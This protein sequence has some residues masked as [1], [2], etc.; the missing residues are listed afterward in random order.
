[1][2]AK[3]LWIINEQKETFV[4]EK[5]MKGL[6]N[7]LG[8]YKDDDGILKLRGRLAE[9]DL[10]ISAKFPIFLSRKSYFTELIIL[11]CHYKLNHSRVKDTLNELRSTYWVPQGR[12]TVTKVIHHCIICSKQESKHFKLL[13]AAPLP[14]F[15]SKVDF[16]FT[17]CGVDL[18]GPLLV[19]N[20]FKPDKEMF[21]VHVVVYTCATSRAVH[22]D[23]V[24]DPTC[25]AFVRS[26]KRFI[27]R[28]GI[29]KL[30]I[31]DNAGCFIGPEL[32]IFVQQIQADWKFILQATPWWGE[33]CP[34]DKKISTKDAQ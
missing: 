2:A 31:S 13:P 21:K 33:N 10:E 3:N 12:R 1:M 15:R 17:T 4:D 30:Y 20:I 6:S 19:K 8:I 11:E 5:L 29:S 23:L 26:L 9:S 22:L 25:L 34:N 16:A 7:S 27:G 14:K 18:L 32:T 28:R 24:P